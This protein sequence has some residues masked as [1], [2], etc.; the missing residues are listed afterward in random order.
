MLI[1]S[2]NEREPIRYIGNRLE[3][4][5]KKMTLMNSGYLLFVLIIEPLHSS[6]V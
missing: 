4:S 5:I 6:R 3:R 2:V 1:V